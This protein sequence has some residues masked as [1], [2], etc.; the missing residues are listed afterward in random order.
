MI[1]LIDIGNSR[2]KYCFY[3]NEIRGTINYIPTNLLSELCFEKILNKVNRIVVASVGHEEISSKLALHCS[4]ANIDYYS[5]KS[6]KTK[7]GVTSAYTKPEKLGVDR[8]LTLLASAKLYPNKNI[9]II[10]AGTATTIDLLDVTGK[11]LGGWI[12]AGINTLL[13]SLIK[14]TN[15]VQVD[16]ENN[17]ANIKFGTDTTENVNNA[18][19]AATMGII[20]QAVTEAKNIDVEIDRIILTGGHA[21]DIENLLE[22]PCI[23]I[24]DLIFYG[25]EI[26]THPA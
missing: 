25:L 1:A 20:Q 24:D 8:W 5:V 9:L 15:K 10:D 4:K 2:T 22:D 23:R 16:T 12:L 18:C 7:N 13:T 26:Y 21:E 11:H 17:I 19:W 14:S 3:E 6:E